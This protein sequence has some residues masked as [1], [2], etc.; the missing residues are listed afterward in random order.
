MTAIPPAR[1][2][3][4]EIFDLVNSLRHAIHA[5]YSGDEEHGSFLRGSGAEYVPSPHMILSQLEYKL[6][7]ALASSVEGDEQQKKKDH[8]GTR[9]TEGDAVSGLVPTPQLTH[10]AN[11][12]E[13][14]I[15]LQCDNCHRSYRFSL[16]PTGKAFRIANILCVCNC[17]IKPRPH[18]SAADLIDYHGTMIVSEASSSSQSEAQESSSQ[19]DSAPA[20]TETPE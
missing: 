19:P 16:R 20:E 7:E 4:S 5:A 12:R 1:T 11:E 6:V 15:T 3:K 13:P 2:L 18:R 9:L 14:L 8:G 17:L 10:D